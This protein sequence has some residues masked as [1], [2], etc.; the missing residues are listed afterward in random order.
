MSLSTAAERTRAYFVKCFG[1]PPGWIAAAPGR[2]NLIGEHTDYNNGFVLPMAIDRYTIVAGGGNYSRH[3]TL[4]SIT[5]GDTLNIGLQGSLERG[6]PAWG[7]Y[8]R[9]VIAGFRKKKI[10]ISGFDAV[11]NSDVP[12]G[13]GLSSSAALEVA[14]AT[15]LEALTE[16][17]LDPIKKALL[18]QHAEHEFA[19]V[20][21][22]IM[23]QFTSVLAKEKHLL[24][25]DCQ[26]QAVQWVPMTDKSITVMIINTNVRHKLVDG[27]YAKRRAE[28]QTAAHKMKIKSLRDADMA[29]LERNQPQLDPVV[30][31]RA[32]HIITENARTLEAVEAFKKSNW[33][34]VGELMYASHASLREDYA[35]SC[36]ELDAVV[37]IAQSI[38]AKDGM[39][40]CRMTGAGFGGCAV[41]L[42]ESAASHRISREIAD[43]YEMKTD[44]QATFFCSGPAGGARLLK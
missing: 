17:K 15:F 13:G 43:A 7:N 33:P 21:C 20:P 29:M 34:R 5:T 9:G 16:H 14:M 39:I 38:G 36:A 42:V 28:C 6:E 18:C 11:I 35:V 40:G 37:E 8:V 3:A 25:I 27:E 41:A 30:F 19:R 44:R 23:D 32:R 2:V 31:R 24:L 22:G 4:H 26:S 12:L 10:K 1:K